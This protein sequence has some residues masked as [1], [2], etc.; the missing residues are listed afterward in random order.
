MRTDELKKTILK[1]FRRGEFYG[2]DIHKRLDQERIEI[3]RSRLYRVLNDMDREGLL[4]SRWEKSTAGPRK[5]MYVIGKEGYKKLRE[6]HLEAIQTVHD[7]YGDYLMNLY[8]EIR[9]FD[10]IFDWL[11]KGFKG[12]EKVAYLVTGNSPMHEMVIRSLSQRVSQGRIYVIASKNLTRELKIETGVLLRGGYDN[13]PL[14]D[15]FLDMILCI[16]LPKIDV[17]KETLDELSRV[18]ND[19]GKMGVITPTIL[20]KEHE[21]PL[22]IGDYIEIYEHEVIERG[23]HLEKEDLQ[24]LM[25]SKFKKIKEKELVHL[26]LLLA[27]KPLKPS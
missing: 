17:L 9:V 3:E 12:D 24:T 20:L 18:L 8:P 1:T 15:R 26:T 10:D 22:T 25:K 19:D 4:S 11:T 5:K 7:F 14:R 2:Y 16:S 23:E 27:S 21:D 13:I 6:I